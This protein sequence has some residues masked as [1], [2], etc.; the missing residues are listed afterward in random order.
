MLKEKTQKKV[1]FLSDQYHRPL[2]AIV[3]V[4][5]IHKLDFMVHAKS[6][7]GHHDDFDPN[8][9]VGYA[10]NI[11]VPARRSSEIF[12]YMTKGTRSKGT[13]RLQNYD[14]VPEASVLYHDE[15]G[16]LNEDQMTMSSTSKDNSFTY[17]FSYPEILSE[18]CL[19]CV[20]LSNHV[21]WIQALTVDYV[22]SFD[23]A[24]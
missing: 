24:N 20:K 17:A 22:V 13:L 15:K 1:C 7:D 4:Q 3:S 16:R 23:K 21:S 2:L 8:E 5:V 11:S 18:D 9:P 10:R 6:Q 12:I 14:S 19:L